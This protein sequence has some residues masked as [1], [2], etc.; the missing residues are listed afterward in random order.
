M[1]IW[2]VDDNSIV[3][4]FKWIRLIQ[5]LL[6]WLYYVIYVHFGLKLVEYDVTDLIESQLML[7]RQWIVD[8]GAI[9]MAIS[10]RSWIDLISI[11]LT[12]WIELIS[13]KSWILAPFW[14]QFWREVES[15]QFQL[16][17]LNWLTSNLELWRLFWGI[18][19]EKLD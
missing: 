3:A 12:K 9:L 2:Y 5:W 13:I 6:T 4:M 15:I 14:W 10:M 17:Q 7:L 11:D 8:F 18:F 19:D 16:I 1:S